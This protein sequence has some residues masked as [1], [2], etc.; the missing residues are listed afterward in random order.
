LRL[1][2]LYNASHFRVS[3]LK[4]GSVV[5][6]NGVQPEIDSTGRASDLFRRVATRVDLIDTSFPYPSAAVQTTGD[7]CKS[8]I[9]T[10]STDD[11]RNDCD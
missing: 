6:F 9:V 7:F 10:G 1:T 5:Q 3:L 2:S 4:N 8:F 11:Y